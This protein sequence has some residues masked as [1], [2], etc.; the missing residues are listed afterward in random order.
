[1][2]SPSSLC[3]CYNNYFSKQGSC[4]LNV[5]FIK[6]DTDPETTIKNKQLKKMGYKTVYNLFFT[7]YIYIHSP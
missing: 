7:I 5:H 2:E 1:M 6:L 4:T 3:E